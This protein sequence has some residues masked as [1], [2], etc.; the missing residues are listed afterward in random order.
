MA[1]KEI[2]SCNTCGTELSVN[3]I[4]IESLQSHI[5][6]QRRLKS[7]PYTPRT[8]GPDTDTITEILKFLDKTILHIYLNLTKK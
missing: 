1:K 2:P 6:T 8:L 4:I 7:T 3:H 5:R